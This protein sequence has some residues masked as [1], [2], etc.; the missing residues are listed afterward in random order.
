MTQFFHHPERG[1]WEAISE[2]SQRILDGYP[3][4][5]IEVPKRPAPHYKWQD[6]KWVEGEVPT[7]DPDEIRARTSVSVKTFCRNL[8]TYQILPASEAAAAARGEWPA[9]F[10]SALTGMTEAE[11]A[12]AE[13]DW[14]GTTVVDRMHPMIVTLQQQ[15]N[16]PMAVVDALFGLDF[17]S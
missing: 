17:G 11:Q 7:P 3:N 5:T 15:A 13:I 10:A 9:T 12:M 14:A 6:G 4:G 2:P 1:Y 8:V 16:I